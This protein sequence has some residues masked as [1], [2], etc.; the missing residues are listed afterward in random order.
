MDAVVGESDGAKLKRIIMR[1]LAPRRR[2]LRTAANASWLARLSWA[3]VRK[4]GPA[5]EQ[6]L[7][8]VF[9]SF[10]LWTWLKWLGVLK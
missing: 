9:I 6:I 5:V 8:F 1:I 7:K 2:I 4:L 10:L 3:G